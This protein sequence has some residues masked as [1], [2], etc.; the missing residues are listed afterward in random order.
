MK[1]PKS[2]Y[3]NDVNHIHKQGDAPAEL[4]TISEKWRELSDKEGDHGS[5]VLGA[6]F[7]FKHQKKWY[8]MGPRSRWQ[9]SCSWEVY[10]DT[11]RADLEAL[12]VSDLRYEWGNMD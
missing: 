2:I 12:G 10:I 1:H 4:W 7:L 9:G 11:I 3:A 8:F 6:G 5:C